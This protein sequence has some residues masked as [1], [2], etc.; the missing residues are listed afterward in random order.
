MVF[1]EDCELC[2]KHGQPSNTSPVFLPMESSL[3]PVRRWLLTP[4]HL[5]TLPLVHQR[6]VRPCSSLL[7]FPGFTARDYGPARLAA[8]IAAAS[9]RRARQD[10]GSFLVST[11]LISSCHVTNVEWLVNTYFYFYLKLFICKMMWQSY[12]L[13][14]LEQFLFNKYL[15]CGIFIWKVLRN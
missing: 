10:W 15:N 12:L 11:D 4:H 5:S 13:V 3:N 7:Y 1:P 14:S 6:P 2:P 8:Y 9:T